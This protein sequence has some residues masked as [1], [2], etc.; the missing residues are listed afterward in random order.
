MNRNTEKRLLKIL[1]AWQIID[2]LISIGYS[3]YQRYALTP[4]G[5]DAS[6][7][8]ILSSLSGNLATVASM[9]GIILIAFGMMNI[10]VAQ[11]Y[12]RA[13][14]IHKKVGIWLGIQ[15]VFSYLSLDVPGAILATITLVILLGKNKSIRLQ[16]LAK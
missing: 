16:Q 7:E 11:N 9:F 2:G 12:I 4:K 8:V 6:E 1:A 13:D 14:H 10:V 5:A 15:A 3:F